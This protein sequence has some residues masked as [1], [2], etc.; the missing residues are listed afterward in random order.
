MCEFEG[1]SKASS[2][3]IEAKLT[4]FRRSIDGLLT[5]DHLKKIR[6][7]L[8]LN[9][10]TMAWLLSVNS[11]TIGRY[12]NGRITQSRQIEKLYRIFE[13]CPSIVRM[14]LEDSDN[15]ILSKSPVVEGDYYPTSNENWTS[16]KLKT[17]TASSAFF[18]R[19]KRDQSARFSVAI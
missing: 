3:R 18:N 1:L 12:E 2:R 19:E 7:Q 5:G 8:G 15:F 4:D 11:K 14:F 10:K 9:I 13:M 16:L 17:V 6:I